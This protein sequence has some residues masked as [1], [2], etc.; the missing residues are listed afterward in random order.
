MKEEK[1][2]RSGGRRKT[3]S[4]QACS[5][6]DLD[7]GL[8]GPSEIKHHRLSTF[9]IFGAL[10]VIQFQRLRVSSTC[11]RHGIDDVRKM[12][13]RKV[14]GDLRIWK[15]KF[16][17][18]IYFTNRLLDSFIRLFESFIRFFELRGI[19]QKDGKQTEK[20]K[21]KSVCWMWNRQ[22]VCDHPLEAPLLT[23]LERSSSYFFF[24]LTRG[25]CLEY[26]TNIYP[27][28]RNIL[29]RRWLASPCTGSR[30]YPV[31]RNEV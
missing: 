15:K 7:Y 21:K 5:L 3:K 6:Y 4:R 1:K 28:K 30:M 29:P 27:F 11:R 18:L 10:K 9:L 26:K 14:S 2:P 20:E 23:V 25:K 24:F 8:E 31:F 16:F 17:F 12:R 13:K 22:P 19:I